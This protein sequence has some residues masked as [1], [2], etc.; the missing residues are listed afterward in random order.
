MLTRLATIFVLLLL[1]AQTALASGLYK[2][3]TTVEAISSYLRPSRIEID[4]TYGQIPRMEMVVES[5]T[6]IP[7]EA[8]ITRTQHRLQLALDDP[9]RVIPIYNPET[10]E[11]TGG[12]ITAAEFY[13]IVYSTFILAE[14]ATYP[15]PPAD[16]PAEMIDIIMPPDMPMEQPQ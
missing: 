3:R 9:A 15:P 11:P 10:G 6:M 14:Q 2:E 16:I 12:A 5:I 8:P 1:T 7:N 13:A 4:N